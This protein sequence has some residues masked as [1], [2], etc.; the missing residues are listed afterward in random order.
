MVKPIKP[1]I[2]ETAKRRLVGLQYVSPDLQLTADLS[3]ERFAIQT[4]AMQAKVDEHNELLNRLAA[5]RAELKTMTRSLSQLSER[6][7]HSI[8][9]VH[10]KESEEYGLVGGTKRIPRKTT[11]K[12]ESDSKS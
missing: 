7:L 9:A 2:L 12:D 4:A 10:G 3:V 8:A 1:K 6:M 5:S 11:A